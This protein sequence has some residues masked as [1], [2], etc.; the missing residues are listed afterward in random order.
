VVVPVFEVGVDVAVLVLSRVRKGDK[1]LQVG[2][3]GLRATVLE[4]I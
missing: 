1:V 2:K 3:E 4:S